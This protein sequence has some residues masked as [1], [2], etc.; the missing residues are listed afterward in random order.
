MNAE[1]REAI[2]SKAFRSKG[3]N[4]HIRVTP[5][6]PPAPFT[7]IVIA[8]CGMGCKVPCKRCQ[9]ECPRLA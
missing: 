7:H 2:W 5:Q 3:S 8:P 6:K 9:I 1:Q 4:D